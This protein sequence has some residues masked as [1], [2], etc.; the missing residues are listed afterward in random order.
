MLVEEDDPPFANAEKKDDRMDDELPL[1]D[2]RLNVLEPD[3]PEGL[4]AETALE[5][6]EL[7]TSIDWGAGARLRRLWRRDVKGCWP[8]L[9][10]EETGAVDFD[11]V[12]LALSVLLSGAVEVDGADEVEEEED[13]RAAAPK[14]AAPTSADACPPSS[15]PGLSSDGSSVVGRLLDGVCAAGEERLGTGPLGFGGREPAAEW[16]DDGEGA[17]GEDDPPALAGIQGRGE[18][19]SERETDPNDNESVEC[20]V[21]WEGGRYGIE[22]GCSRAGERARR[23]DDVAAAGLSCQTAT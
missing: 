22:G 20:V 3:V 1:P 2:P 21:A 13:E 17:P 14:P 11:S 18:L 5:A 23:G 10:V 19:F 16:L 4:L 7:S 9:L 8:D 6:E 15:E 12:G